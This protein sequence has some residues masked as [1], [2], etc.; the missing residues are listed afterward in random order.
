MQHP[1]LAKLNA[2]HRRFYFYE[3]GKKGGCRV[4]DGQAFPAA[5]VRGREKLWLGWDWV[6][7]LIQSAG[8]SAG[9]SGGVWLP[10]PVGLALSFIFCKS[11]LIVERHTTWNKKLGQLPTFTQSLT[12]AWLCCAARFL[13]RSPQRRGCGA[14]RCGPPPWPAQSS[15]LTHIAHFIQSTILYVTFSYSFVLWTCKNLL[16]VCPS[17]ERDYSHVALPEVSSIF[18]ILRTEDVTHCVFWL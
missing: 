7:M 10:C 17:W 8:L 16:H 4:G 13:S 18:F 14:V 11:L 1:E 15:S 2:I 9:Y 5:A 3:A 12:K 6:L